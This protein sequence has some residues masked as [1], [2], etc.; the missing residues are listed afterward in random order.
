M[1][2]LFASGM[3]A[4]HWTAAA[5]WLIFGVLAFVLAA[6]VWRTLRGSDERLAAVGARLGSQ[7]ND[8]A[9]N[10]AAHGWGEMS[11]AVG[12]G[13]CL[14]IPG[15]DEVGRIQAKVGREGDLIIFHGASSFM[16]MVL[17]T[18]GIY[19]MRYY[20]MQM[21][22]Y[23]MQRVWKTFGDKTSRERA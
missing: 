6:M 11:L 3:V 14:F 23:I 1:S 15:D 12:A 10:M 5:G 19:W 16:G 21:K 20:H 17:G 18:Q 2:G 8:K 7:P 9:E 4:W 22:K 13:R